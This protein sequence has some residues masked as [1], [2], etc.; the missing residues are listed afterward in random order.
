[1]DEFGRALGLAVAMILRA[2]PDLVAIVGLSLRVSL[3]AAA[4]G[5]VLGAPLGAL[6]AATRFPGRA[7]L[8]VLLNAL[9][10]LPPVVVGLVLYLLVSRSGPLGSL[11]LLFTPGA[12]VIAQGALALP[13]VAALAHRTCEALWAEYGDALRVDGVG[14]GHAA[15]ILLAMAPAPLVTAFLAAFGRAIAEVGAILMVG[16]NIRG[17]TRTMTTSIALETSRGDLALALGLGLV[18]VSLTLVVSAAAFGINRVAA[19]PRA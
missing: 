13:I 17:Y 5:F 10:G 3:T 2:D 18:L 6:L 19:L 15:L 14:P 4:L 8:L 12:M 7:A 11:G 9:L 1:M 16:G